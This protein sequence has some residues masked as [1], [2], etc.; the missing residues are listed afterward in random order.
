MAGRRPSRD[1]QVIPSHRRQEA[2]QQAGFGLVGA[3]PQALD[4]GRLP[5]TCAMLPAASCTPPVTG[6]SLSKAADEKPPW[7]PVP[8]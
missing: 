4:L 7:D 5:V 8:L 1:S 6:S 3:G 2:Q